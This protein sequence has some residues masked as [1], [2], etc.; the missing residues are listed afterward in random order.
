MTTAPPPKG[1]IA[2]DETFDEFPEQQG[3]LAETEEM[4]I[5]ELIAEQ[6]YIAMEQEGVTKT[7]PTS[8]R[9]ASRRQP[10]RLLDPANLSVTLE[11]LCKQ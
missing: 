5:K 2:Y 6:L 10:D 3:L 4:A 8:R 1:R 7:A 11:V 9:Q